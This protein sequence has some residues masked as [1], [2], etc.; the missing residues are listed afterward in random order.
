MIQTAGDQ[1]KDLLDEMERRHN[2]GDSAVKPDEL[3]Y[4][5]AI[6]TCFHVANVR[7]ADELI[8]R[9]EKSDTLATLLT[10][11]CILK[12]LSVVGNGDQAQKTLHFLENK[13]RDEDRPDLLPDTITYNL[14]LSAMAKSKDPEAPDH[15]W[16]F[17]NQ[18]T[19]C[20]PPDNA[21]MST[22]ISFFTKFKD[23]KQLQ[24]ADTLLAF[25]CESYKS[26][27]SLTP[28][29]RYFAMIVKGWLGIGETKMA[30]YVLMR[31]IDFCIDEKMLDA[32]ADGILMDMVIQSYMKSG[33]ILRATVLVNELA[34]MRDAKLLP[35]GP[36][37]NTYHTLITAWK[38]SKLK[39]K[40]AYM[41]K[42]WE[43][44]SSL[45]GKKRERDHVFE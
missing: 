21:T 26:G 28:D 2:A 41:E 37:H 44:A 6:K 3:S 34:D 1:A 36:N 5:T 23:R 9:L 39:G 7:L 43:R 20:V 31:S 38:A 8:A 22:V 40:E 32:A 11:K 19:K 45:N 4:A 12:H 24:R 16:K 25:M 42:L 18:M 13:A 33:E 10:Y 29:H 14:V 27:K 15:L 17:Y 35:E 30:E